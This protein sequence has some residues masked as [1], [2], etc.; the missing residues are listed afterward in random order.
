VIAVAATTDDGCLASYSNYGAGVDLVAP[1][2]GND[3]NVASDPDCH[4]GRDGQSIYQVTLAGPRLDHFETVGYIGTSM[5]TP[6]VAATAA[7]VVA[8]GVLGAAS[9]PDDIEARLEQTSRDLGKPGFDQVYG[10]G[11][12][13]AAAATAPGTAH[14]PD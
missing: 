9:S 2:G 8:S 14:R 1:G 3:A 10:W 13:N 7:L 5:A 4:V 6:H 12:V 11:L